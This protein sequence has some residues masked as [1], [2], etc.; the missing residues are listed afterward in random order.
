MQ[1]LR[2]KFD[3]LQTSLGILYVQLKL[4]YSLK[5]QDVYNPKA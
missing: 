1:K 4:K 3:R 5:I 2:D